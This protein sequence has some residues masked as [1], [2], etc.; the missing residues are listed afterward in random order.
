MA[1]LMI[2]PS[3]IWA[4]NTRLSTAELTELSNNSALVTGYNYWDTTLK[5]YKKATSPTTLEALTAPT[6][7]ML[8]TTELDTLKSSNQIIIGKLYWNTETKVYEK[9]ASV[10]ST[11]IVNSSP[12][13]KTSTELTA[14]NA[15]K[16][17]TPDILYWNTQS[18]RYHRGQSD[19]SL[20]EL[21]LHDF[22]NN[23]RIQPLTVIA[24]ADIITAL[25]LKLDT[26]NIPVEAGESETITI[27]LPELTAGGLAT[28]Q[29]NNDWIVTAE[30][31]IDSTN[32]S[33]GTWTTLPI[34]DR[35]GGTNPTN[36]LQ[37]INLPIGA[38]SWIRI[39]FQNIHETKS[40][41]FKNIGLRKFSENNDDDY[42]LFLGDSNSR[43]GNQYDGLHQRAMETYDKD[44]IIFSRATPGKTITWLNDNI[45]SILTN[46]PKARFVTVHIG[47]RDITNNARPMITPTSYT[48]QME[49]AYR[50]I[51]SKIKTSGKIPIPAR[52][53][54]SAYPNDPTGKPGTY[55]GGMQKHGSLPFNQNIFDP[56]IQEMTPEFYNE[57]AGHGTID[58][59]SS[60]LN[61]QTGLSTNGISLNTMGREIWMDTWRDTAMKT[62]YTVMRPSKITPKYIGSPSEDAQKV[63]NNARTSAK[64]SDLNEA[65]MLI[66][67][68]DDWGEFF[69][70]KVTLQ[71]QLNYIVPTVADSQY[72][73]DFGGNTASE[74]N[75]N[76]ITNHTSGTTTLINNAGDISTLQLEITQPF[77]RI[78][79]DRGHRM[80]TLP[81]S[82]TKDRFYLRSSSA[83]KITLSDLDSGKTYSLS[84]YSSYNSNSSYIT[85]FEIN[86]TTESV[87]STKNDSEVVVFENITPDGSNQIIIDISTA[88]YYGHLNALII[89]ESEG[90]PTCS[91]D[92][93]NGDETG[94]DCGGSCPA[95]C[96]PAFCS[97]AIHDGD[98]TG[99]DCGGSCPTACPTCTDGI[100][101]GNEEKIDCGGPDCATCPDSKYLI[102]LGRNTIATSGNWNNISSYTSGQL[103]GLID[104]QGSSSDISLT[105][106]QQFRGRNTSGYSTAEI[107]YPDTAK[108]D[109]FYVR[110]SDA[111]AEILVSGLDTDKTYSF[112]FYASRETTNN[113]TTEYTINSETVSLNAANNDTNTVSISNVNPETNGTLTLSITTN[114]SAPYGYLNVLEVVEHN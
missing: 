106:T 30:R 40:R 63:I 60:L 22:N 114:A 17:A 44:P 75:W 15:G 81:A 24:H 3:S 59:Y 23:P 87:L 47:E 41:S 96:A 80:S 56:I 37:K 72:N 95:T 104:D 99:I 91:D 52:V 109:S 88:S 103:V 10:S 16:T 83:P 11:T 112:T 7:S 94:L 110:R 62:I 98:E 58:L 78:G 76:N 27:Q 66:N 77:Y 102:D 73:I 113:R 70:E 100:M 90:A 65:Q 5:A 49:V 55:D 93:H 64:L 92:T 85:D 108:T 53:A 35:W 6:G 42:W 61:N 79:N 45:D 71:S 57:D 51:I 21:S 54:F 50:S 105:I 4:V 48:A 8:T 84:L 9:G 28:Y 34:D 25:N 111:P 67:A 68:L 31:S 19:G 38:T 86:G 97:N 18:K 2:F 69:T 46:H 12:S 32:G 1:A 13:W 107:P 74:G 33:N 39:N 26:E 29:I 101:N 20:K 36:Y 82:A 43:S 14:L 89:N